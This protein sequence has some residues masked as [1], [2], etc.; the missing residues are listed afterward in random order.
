MR[1]MP[2]R[3]HLLYI[4]R[5]AADDYPDCVNVCF[6][7]V[8]RRMRSAAN[9]GGR[10]WEEELGRVSDQVCLFSVYQIGL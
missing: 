10:E 6:W 3:F 2:D 8:P 5:E 7:Y 4:D 9:K 1:A